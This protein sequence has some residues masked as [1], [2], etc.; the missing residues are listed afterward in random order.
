MTKRENL[1]LT[2]PLFP[3]RILLLKRGLIPEMTFCLSPAEITENGD[4][5]TAAD[6][7]HQS[8]GIHLLLPQWCQILFRNQF[9]WHYIGTSLMFSPL[10]IYNNSLSHYYTC[11][12]CAFTIKSLC[13]PFHTKHLTSKQWTRNTGIVCHDYFTGK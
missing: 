10:K 13:K 4:A 5:W 9:R 6:W 3:Y 8:S 2:I 11:I 1:V 7:A 12:F